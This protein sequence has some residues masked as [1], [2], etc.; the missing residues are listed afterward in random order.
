MVFTMRARR[1]FCLVAA[2]LL[3]AGCAGSGSPPPKDQLQQVEAKLA[4][5]TAQL[6][7][8]EANL[9]RDIAQEQHAVA[10]ANRYAR[11]MQEGVISKEQSEQTRTNA[12]AVAQ[13]VNADRA[14]IESVK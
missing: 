7:Q 13:G 4:R 5:N 10:Q 8:A 6:R 14:A 12:D 9:A 3:L 1:N 11:L 2:C